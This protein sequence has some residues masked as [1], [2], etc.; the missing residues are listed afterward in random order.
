MNFNYHIDTSNVL[1]DG[2]A[3]LTREPFLFFIRD[4]LVFDMS[5]K[6]DPLRQKIEA[7]IKDHKVA[8]GITADIS[9]TSI[10]LSDIFISSDSIGIVTLVKGKAKLNVTSL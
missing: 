9:I 8:S 4:K 5:G 2:L 10:G 6:I 3:A 1:I 7:G